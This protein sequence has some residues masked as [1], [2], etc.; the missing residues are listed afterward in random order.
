MRPSPQSRFPR[1][2]A[3]PPLAA[4][5]QLIGLLGGSFNPPHAAHRLISEV[6][7]K[8]LGLAKVWWIVSPGNPLKRRTE[9]APLERR[10]VLCRETARNPHIVVTDFEADLDEPFTAAT[11]AFLRARTPLVRYVWLMG[12]DNLASFERWQRWREIFTMVPIVVV[13]RPG[14]RLKALASKAA[15]AF[16]SSRVPEAE[17]RSLAHRPPPAWTF[18]TGPLSS[19]SST[20][21]RNRAKRSPQPSPKKTTRRERPERSRSAPPPGKDAG[22]PMESA[23]GDTG[24]SS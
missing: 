5:G 12:A 3:R 16:A 11:L 10:V 19:M 8:R 1:I 18:L 6:A 14:W 20:T 2:T 23:S 13:D 9:M 24:K 21:L 17:A 22:T 4:P 15:R 7:L